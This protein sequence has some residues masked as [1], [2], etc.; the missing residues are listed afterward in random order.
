M[1]KDE[2]GLAAV[3]LLLLSLAF[4][5]YFIAFLS[6]SALGGLGYLLK[7]L[8]EEE[9]L[10]LTEFEREFRQGYLLEQENKYE[11]AETIYLHLADKYP[12]FSYI[13]QERIKFIKNELE[14]RSLKTIVREENP[15]DHHLKVV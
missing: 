1:H 15:P 6:A 7:S 13:A 14:V 9:R 8:N 10:E 12:K 3:G 2:Y 11:E 5:P 4:P